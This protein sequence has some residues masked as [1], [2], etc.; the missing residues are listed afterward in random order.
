MIGQAD[1]DNTELERRLHVSYSQCQ[2]IVARA[3]ENQNRAH[4]KITTILEEN[5]RDKE[6]MRN[7]MQEFVTQ[8]VADVQQLVFCE[9]Q[10]AQL[11][12]AVTRL[13][14]A[15]TEGRMG[16]TVLQYN[17]EWA[18]ALFKYGEEDVSKLW[19]CNKLGHEVLSSLS[20]EYEHQCNH[21]GQE[22][23]VVS[24]ANSPRTVNKC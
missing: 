7:S 2:H 18:Q 9:T 3:T 22:V 12:T 11:Q 21:Y 6:K 15:E 23:R 10:Y 4:A 13:Q 24:E 17:L 5:R 16:N 8:G 1:S 14:E 19:Q 20:T